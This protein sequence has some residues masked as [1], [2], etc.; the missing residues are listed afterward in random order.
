MIMERLSSDPMYM[1]EDVLMTTM[2]YMSG[3]EILSLYNTDKKFR[4]LVNFVTPRLRES[5]LQKHQKIYQRVYRAFFK[6]DERVSDYEVMVHAFSKGHLN[7][8]KSFITIGDPTRYLMNLIDG[9]G[10]PSYKAYK[11]GKQ[12][13]RSGLV[14]FL[15]EN[16]ADIHHNRDHAL[17][18]SVCKGTKLF[19]LLI[20]LGADIHARNEGAI[21]EAIRCFNH[22]AVERLVQEGANVHVNGER[23]LKD[24]V[25]Y[26]EDGPREPGLKIIRTLIRAGADVKVDNSIL[27]SMTSDPV[28]I[29]MLL[30]AGADVRATPDNPG[31]AAGIHALRRAAENGALQSVRLLLDAG[32]DVHYD[33]DSALRIAAFNGH[34]EVVKLL[35]ERGAN[36]DAGEGEALREAYSIN[37]QSLVEILIDAGADEELSMSREPLRTMQD[38]EEN[39][40]LDD[41]DYDSY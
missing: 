16:G 23:L 30:K 8:A 28:A 27:L 12:D 4:E 40:Y 1:N 37:N 3:E 14:K 10:I 2:E 24:A 19:Q 13:E 7:V 21:K 32:A 11:M 31:D 20:E 22:F 29:K 38:L 25:M 6:I 5:V 17:I 34:L 18:S 36:V 26:L 15:I 35:I 39:P 33:D 9:L 41:Y